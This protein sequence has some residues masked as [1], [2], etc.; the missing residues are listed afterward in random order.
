MKSFCQDASITAKPGEFWRKMRPLL[1]KTRCNKNK[2]YVLIENEKVITDPKEI[3]ETFNF[4]M[5][6]HSG[7]DNM[8]IHDFND[9]SSVQKINDN[10]STQTFSFETFNANYIRNILNN[11]NFKKS[12]GFDN[13]SSKLLK[14]SSLQR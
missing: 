4:A 13:I 5:V 6:N 1:P 12:V 8:D 3:A 10:K 2:G 11:L 9:H 14:L 7:G